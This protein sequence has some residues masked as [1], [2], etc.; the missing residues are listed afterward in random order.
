MS[1]TP[2]PG[3]P[4]VVVLRSSEPVQWQ[5]EIVALRDASLAVRLPKAPDSW[6]SLLPYMIICGQPG[7]RFTAQASFV[8][9][10]GDVAA[11]KLT[12]RWKPLDLRRDQRF[13][14]D[15]RAEVRS[16]LGS[17]RQD[18]RII[19]IS[20]GGAAIAVETRPGGS[21]IEIGMAANG[22]GARLLCDVLSSSE[23]GSD[24]VLHVRFRDLTPPQHAFIRQ[25]VAGLLQAT[26]KAS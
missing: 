12:S 26:V 8:A 1:V 4:V 7:S 9:R 21:Q 23:V 16:V 6:N 10:N 24:T 25:L 22:Y 5:G 20:L 15:L 13:S 2:E 3:A 17:S 18:G 19:D 14:T 11:F